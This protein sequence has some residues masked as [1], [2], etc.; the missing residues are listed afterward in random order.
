[1]DQRRPG[2]APSPTNTLTCGERPLNSAQKA[3]IPRLRIAQ[4]DPT[5]PYHD[6]VRGRYTSRKKPPSTLRCRDHHQQPHQYHRQQQQQQ[7]RPSTPSSTTTRRSVLSARCT[8]AD[9]HDE[10]RHNRACPKKLSLHERNIAKPAAATDDRR[11]TPRKHRDIALRA[12]AGRSKR[13]CDDD[14][15]EEV[16]E[17]EKLDF[18]SRWVEERGCDGI[19]CR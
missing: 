1:M 5:L 9:A 4:Y 8:N 14:T 6:Q 17:S 3:G 13:V 19:E 16:S 12:M 18:V 15:S 10:T 11:A 7:Q 2:T